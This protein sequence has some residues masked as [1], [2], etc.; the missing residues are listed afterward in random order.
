MSGRGACPLSAG[1][2][3]GPSVDS[4]KRSAGSWSTHFGCIQRNVMVLLAV[5]T[6]PLSAAPSVVV[7][8]P[9][10]P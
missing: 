9:E 4:R 10:V 6:E 8:V 3:L 5:L 2:R 1:E 7:S